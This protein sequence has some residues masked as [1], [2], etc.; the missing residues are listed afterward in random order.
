MRYHA[1]ETYCSSAQ[2]WEAVGYTMLQ[3]RKRF[4][5]YCGLYHMGKEPSENNG[6]YVTSTRDAYWWKGWRT[7]TTLS[8]KQSNL[9]ANKTTTTTTV[10]ITTT[11][12]TCLVGACSAW[13]CLQCHLWVWMVLQ[14]NINGT[15]LLM[16]CRQWFIFLYRRSLQQATYMEF[17]H[18]LLA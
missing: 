18:A 6:C 11:I 5:I 9:S 14:P 16:L 8:W 15:P 17:K 1:G 3:L 2:G 12:T 7:G 10:R 13:K 4:K